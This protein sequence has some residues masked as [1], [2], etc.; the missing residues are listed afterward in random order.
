MTTWTTFETID[1]NQSV[2]RFYVDR[3]GVHQFR[4]DDRTRFE[5]A[6]VPKPAGSLVWSAIDL[7]GE[8]DRAEFATGSMDAVIKFIAGRVLY[9]A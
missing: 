7:E 2:N 6:R 4:Q 5:V 8:E 1:E 9:G 3:L